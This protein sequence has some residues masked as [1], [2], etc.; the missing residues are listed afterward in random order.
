MLS[1]KTVSTI[2]KVVMI[3]TLTLLILNS[4]PVEATR[5]LVAEMKSNKLETAKVVSVSQDRA[6]VTPS[7]PNPCTYLPGSD[8][9]SDRRY[10]AAS[11]GLNLAAS[12][13]QKLFPCLMQGAG[14]K[15]AGRE[16]EKIRTKRL[17]VCC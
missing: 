11:F 4:K 7:E 14:E 3:V 10:I 9:G 2:V 15:R 16:M 5:T 12:G 1:E 17:K 8:N 13:D 6:P